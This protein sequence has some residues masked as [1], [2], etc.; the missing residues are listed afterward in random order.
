MESHVHYYIYK[1]T[2]HVA[3]SVGK[4][5]DLFTERK[6]LLEIF[7]TILTNHSLLRLL[8]LPQTNPIGFCSGQCANGLRDAYTECGFTGLFN[9][10]E[11]G[12]LQ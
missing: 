10:M 9:P 11:L 2:L 1:L 3:V 4:L 5:G 12:I 8:M 6:Q 7:D